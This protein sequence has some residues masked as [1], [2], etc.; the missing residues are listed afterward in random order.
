MNINSIRGKKLELLA[1]LDFQQPHVVAIQETKIDY[2]NFRIT[3]GNLPIQCIQKRQE[4]SWRWYN[5]TCSQGYPTHAHY[6]TGKQ[7]GVS[8]GLSVCK[9][10]FS[11]YGKLVSAT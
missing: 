6:R 5:V 11:L 2:C 10:N 4:S 3:S 8:L 1:F 9:Q 7:L